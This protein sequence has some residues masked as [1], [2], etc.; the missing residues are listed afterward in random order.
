MYLSISKH[1]L[2]FADAN[3][4]AQHHTEIGFDGEERLR[5]HKGG[6]VGGLERGS[7]V[8]GGLDICLG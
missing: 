3:N 7:Q 2:P 5:G 8:L 1:R 6:V 4:L